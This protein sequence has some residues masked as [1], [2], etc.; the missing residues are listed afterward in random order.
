M[1]RLGRSLQIL[2]LVLLPLSMLLELDGNLGRSFG[3]SD[4][5]VMLLF[6]AGA[7]AVG[8]LVEGYARV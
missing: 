7:F 5:V 1:K 2:G 4:M 6:G 8:W 3:V